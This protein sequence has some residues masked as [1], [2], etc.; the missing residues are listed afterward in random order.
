MQFLKDEPRYC[1]LLVE[2]KCD[3]SIE[4]KDSQ[5]LNILDISKIFEISL[6]KLILIKEVQP[7]HNDL[8][9]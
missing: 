6:G 2:I 1:R 9:L 3:K 7:S 5:L 4:T 8:I